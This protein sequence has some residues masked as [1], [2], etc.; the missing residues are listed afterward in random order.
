MDYL[1]FGSSPW[2]F[3]AV[4]ILVLGAAVELPIL[5]APHFRVAR[6]VPDGLWNGIQSG[7]LTLV[8]FML[9]ISFSQSATRY[10]TRRALVISEANAIG[11]TWLRADQLP[12]SQAARFRAILAS[13]TATR[14]RQYQGGRT[15]RARDIDQA[16][17]DR[18]QA[19]LWAVAS[20]ALRASP[21]NLGRSLL[22]QSLNDTIDIS[23]EQRIALTNHV[24]T[25]VVTLTL[26][27]VVLG[28]ILIGLSFARTRTPPRMLGAVFVAAMVI[29]LSMLVDLDRPQRGFIRVSLEPLVVQLQSM[30]E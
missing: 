20:A 15:S 23:A 21:Q 28:T 5:V 10:D 8:A 26:I 3:P 13:Y 22:M 24:P 14:L 12:G 4:T 6:Q 2:L 30:R 25:S 9:G 19:Q 17:S 16:L 7:I 18:E 1:L 29:V 11:T 27:L